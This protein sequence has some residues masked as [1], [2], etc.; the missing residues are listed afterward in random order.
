MGNIRN[1]IYI[2]YIY[3][4]LFKNVVLRVLRVV[5]HLNSMV[6]LEL[7]MILRLVLRVLRV[8]TQG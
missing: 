7:R 2:I 8:V 5:I 4:Y 1:T 6:N 3:I